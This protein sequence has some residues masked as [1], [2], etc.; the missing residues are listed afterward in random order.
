MLKCICRIICESFTNFYKFVVC[1]LWFVCVLSLCMSVFVR[2]AAAA[3]A[4]QLC[5]CHHSLSF[6]ALFLYDA[7]LQ[8]FVYNLLGKLFN[9]RLET[10]T[11]FALLLLELCCGRVVLRI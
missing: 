4:G 9:L 10:C 5:V 11:S 7:N 2:C 3:V 1:G 6:S 8:N